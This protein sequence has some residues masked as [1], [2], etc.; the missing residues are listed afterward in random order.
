MTTGMV[1]GVGV[2]APSSD[3]HRRPPRSRL[4]LALLLAATAAFWLIG[5]GRNGWANAFYAG[6]VQAG[7]QDWTAAFFGSSDAANSI[8]VDKPPASLWP[9]ELSARL[10][11]LNTWTMLVPQVL[12]GVAAV[13]L[14][15]FA[16][17][18]TFGPT[19][20]LVAGALLALTPVAT[21]MFRYN[22]PDALLVVV[23]VAAAWAVLRAVGD[24]RTRWLVL[25]GAMVGLGFLAKQLQIMLIVPALAGTYLYCGPPRLA[26]RVRQLAAAALAMIVTAGW[27]VAAV[28]LTP[29]TERPFVGG[30]TTN[31]FVDLTFGY[32]GLSRLTGH[33][34][35]A[36]SVHTGEWSR[37]HV[38]PFRLFTGE[39][40]GQISWLLP[41]ALI[42]LAAGLAWSRR[43]PRT[44]ARR[45]H[46]LLWGGWLLVGGTVMSAM[47][48][49]YHDYYT[50]ALA[51]AVAALVALGGIE[52][53][54]RRKDRS[55]RLLLAASIAAT[56]VWSSIVLSRTPAF[57]PA[58]RWVVLVFG[59]VAAAGIV[60]RSQR[61][62]VVVAAAAAVLAGPLA[63][64]IQTITTAHH[65][66]I[67][68][69]G[70]ALPGADQGGT[71]KHWMEPVDVT[72][73]MTRMLTANAADFTWVAATQGGNQAAAYQLATGKPVMPIGGFAGRD[74][75]PTLEQFRDDVAEGRIHYFID[76]HRPGDEEQKPGGP[77]D[78]ADGQAARIANWVKASFTPH[79][80]DGVSFYDLTASR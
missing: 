73:T 54:H 44:D 37:S 69:A 20:G 63:Y 13:A 12:I 18:R 10:F 3:G 67:V 42:A 41:A 58:L 52:C 4:G 29:P 57:V 49:T 75:A 39:S 28:S 48:G 23:M 38:G 60:L 78:S 26:V 9:M 16:V 24:G 31:S 5:L 19:A 64:C 79:T 27:W 21:L 33:R 25:C 6:A 32:N 76:G 70:P 51:P 65:G 80:V 59:L 7:T 47:S 53:W 68:N 46:Y 77:N 40:A 45:A 15:Y 72:D 34:S 71:H 62:V 66:G 36:Q 43:L 74:P 2:D 17:S 61:A 30:S 8:T 22:N 1:A 35:A 56:A 50:V 14:L 11:G 55:A